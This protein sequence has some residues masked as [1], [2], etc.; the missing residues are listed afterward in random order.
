[1]EQLINSA[2]PMAKLKTFPRFITALSEMLE[3]VSKMSDEEKKAWDAEIEEED[4]K[5]ALESRLKAF[6]CCGIGSKYFN[7]DFN[8]FAI[9]DETTQRLI[10]VAKAFC[11]DVLNGNQRHLILFGNC[12]TGKTSISAACLKKIMF[13]LKNT[14]F[15]LP[16]YYSGSYTT[17]VELIQELETVNFHKTTEFKIK[18]ASGADICVF[19]EIG[20]SASKKISESDLIFQLIDNIYQHN[21]SSILIT[22]LTA[23]EFKKFVGNAVISRLKDKGSMMWVDMSNGRDFRMGGKKSVG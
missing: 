22:N 19:D 2:E 21:G 4:K 11:E 18:Q 8:N 9:V 6:Q 3:E 16:V 5:Q 14:V 17:M 15:G 13:G 7:S 23:D 12:G 10:N 20:R 1:M